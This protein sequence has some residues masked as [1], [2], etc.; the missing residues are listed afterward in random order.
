M[1]NPNWETK[2]KS[3][4]EFWWLRLPLKARTVSPVL[5]ETMVDGLYLVAWRQAAAL[6]PAAALLLGILIGWGH[7]G[8]YFVFSESMFVM[9]VAAIFGLMSANL[10]FMFLA[11]FIFGDFFLVYRPWSFPDGIVSHLL[12]VRLPLLIEYGLLWFLVISIPLATKALLSHLPLPKK[13]ENRMKFAALVI[14]HAFLTYFLVYFWTQMVP[15]L[16]RPIFT[17]PGDNPPV[18]PSPPISFRNPPVEAMQPLQQNGMI[19]VYVA[20]LVSIARMA[21]QGMT[22]FIS[23]I[24]NRLDPF[25]RQLLTAKPVASLVARAPLAAR[26]VLHSLW[27]VLMLSGMFAGWIDAALIGALIF[28]IQASRTGL[29]RIPLGP[30]PAIMER[31]PVLLRFAAAVVI[32]YMVSRVVLGWQFAETNS[33][34]PVLVLTGLSVLVFYL[35][36]PGLTRLRQEKGA[37]G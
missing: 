26:D 21:L 18:F 25:E 2:L 17:W 9:V 27:A 14:G 36:N 28:L 5:A 20:V 13:L 1:P 19:L 10:G 6:A 33:F 22:A 8:F 31:L 32:V 37:T 29:L 3:L 15:L 34:R 24:G 30:W 35:A 4:S 11:G 7:F 23:E 16:I 12:Y